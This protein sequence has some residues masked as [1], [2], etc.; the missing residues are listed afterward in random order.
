MSRILSVPALAGTLACLYSPAIAAEQPNELQTLKAQLAAMQQRIGQ[1]EQSQ[2]SQSQ[3]APV[4]SVSQSS[5]NAFNPAISA[6]LNGHYGS[7][8]GNN[9]AIAGFGT[10]EEG[11]RTGEGLAL[12]EAELR[13]TSNVDDKFTAA[14]TAALAME[15]GETE[16]E[17]EEAYIKTLG[18]PYGLSVTAGRFLAPVGY[19]NDHHQHSDDFVDRPLP[20]RVFLNNSYKDN[21]V[22]ASVVLPTEYYSEIGSAV[23]A[24]NDFPGG[25]SDGS[26]PGAWLA[27]GRLGGDIG[28]N[29]SWLA[30]LSMLHSSPGER[31]A[32]EDNILFAGDSA[33]YAASLRYTYAPTGNPKEKELV[34][35]GE[36]MLRDESGIYEDV[37]AGTGGV[38]Y[39]D[40]QSGWYAQGVY[41]FAPSWR[42]GARYS[43]L[44]PGDVP[45][46]LA[47]SELDSSGH[48][49]WNAA[50]M[51]DWTNSEYS[52]IRL[53]AGYEEASA[54]ETDHQVLLQYIMSI[55][56]H[57]A[58]SF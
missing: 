7:F 54:G 45:A 46:G 40:H 47:G 4:V 3:M 43:R 37:A 58:H 22:L 29:Q 9:P 44:N 2:Q 53:Q 30:S 32:N 49:P 28:A 8:S 39:D 26:D 41:K 13:L 11:G 15:D 10:G 51:T 25:G 19:L 36:Y 23:L 57:P 38:N 35:Q 55:G 31:S 33:L 34:L 42:I 1:L 20:N 50:L 27:Y 16:I 52:R 17:L 12:D 56:A 24:G 18:L 6:V 21:G 5:N 48:D 14:V